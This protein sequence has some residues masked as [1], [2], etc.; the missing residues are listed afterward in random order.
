MLTFRLTNTMQNITS[1]WQRAP[2]ALHL[3]LATLL[4]A[5][6]AG[7]ASK[8]KKY[9]I[10][11]SQCSEDSWRSKLHEELDIAT[12]FN[13][14]VTLLYA[15]S[16]DNESLQEKQIAE[17]IDKGIDLLI[18][19]PQQI[20]ELTE[21]VDRAYDRGIPVILFDRK[22][23]SNKY[24]A[25]M[26]ADNY[27]IGCM[28]ADYVSEQ[29]GG[30]G[31]IV[32]V[33][34]LKGST[35]AM[36]RTRGFRDGLEKHPGLKVVAFGNGDWKEKSGREVMDSIMKIYDGPVDCIFGGNDRMAIGARNAYIERHKTEAKT[37]MPIVIGVDALPDEGLGICQV[38]D[39][40]LTASA[41]YPTNGDELI[42][43][44]LKILE[45]RP[46]ERETMM[47]SSIVTD[48]NARVLLLQ[49]EE[50]VRQGN[51]LR[52]MHKRIDK[53]LHLIDAQRT[54]IGGFIFILLVGAFSIIFITRA[55]RQKHR[56]NSELSEKNKLLAQQRDELQQQ[57]DTL[58]EQH[59][60][61][62]EQRDQ[63]E[64]QRD[65]LA[66]QRDE[67]QKLAKLAPKEIDR[68]MTGGNDDTHHEED[69]C[70][71]QR[72]MQ[73]IERN[74]GNSEF[75]VESLSDTIGL[76]R[77][78]MYRRCKQLTGNSPVEI[79]R[80]QRMLRAGQMLSKSDKNISEVTYAC[81]F[82]SPSY[83]TKCF[84][85]HYGMSPTDFIRHQQG[86]KHNPATADMAAN[87]AA[88]PSSPNEA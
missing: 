25:F 45:G 33:G 2:H 67:L 9:V 4:I 84:K 69:N 60:Q 7:C 26:G 54:I 70:F 18:V 73:I 77:A 15:S 62:C 48:D 37:K 19:S 79:L 81:G 50:V 66:L 10:G 21:A 85:D 88:A 39:G 8:E 87:K 80:I 61:L 86:N 22:T 17:M 13:E 83:F 12:Y 57:H 32:E 51:Y 16:D 29:L 47:A 6:V 3:I 72:L 40:L 53:T 27:E 46:F 35:P 28:V 59:D 78:Q 82:T 56:L 76:S 11:V 42:E 44:A 14:G 68:Q 65:E 34:G 30:T 43:L 49:H 52:K 64:A 24:T 5:L 71:F 55:Y 36:D 1:L 74:I 41:I 75:S 31:S 38:R 20:G 63:M 23:G 58:Q